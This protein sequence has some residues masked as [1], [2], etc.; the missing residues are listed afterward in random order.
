MRDRIIYLLKNQLTHELKVFSS[1]Y[2][3]MKIRFESENT[4]MVD[5]KDVHV[6]IHLF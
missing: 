3:N 5:S 1:V 6:Q 2:F 4:E